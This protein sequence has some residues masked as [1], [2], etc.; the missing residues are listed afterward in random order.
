MEVIGSNPISP[1]MNREF[2]PP[3]KSM[4]GRWFRLEWPSSSWAA[5][6][7][8]S[9]RD[10]P[11]MASLVGFPAVAGLVAVVAVLGHG[12]TWSHASWIVRS[13]AKGSVQVTSWMSP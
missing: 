11:E 7:A 10:E 9:R 1:T 5:R 3:A 4:L 2:E 12:V 8:R 6:R 13:S